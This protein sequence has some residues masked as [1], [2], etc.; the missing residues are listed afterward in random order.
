MYARYI[1]RLKHDSEKVL[2]ATNL[3]SATVQINAPDEIILVCNSNIGLIYA[4]GN[5]DAIRDFCK[6]ETNN[7]DLR[8]IAILDP[9]AVSQ[10]PKVQSISKSDQFDMMVRQNPLLKQ[11]KDQ[12]RL[13][14]G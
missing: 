9:T 6:Q 14:I 11:L 12:L 10:A 1:D 5:T 3:A 13:D 2:Q 7:K 8:V 4:S